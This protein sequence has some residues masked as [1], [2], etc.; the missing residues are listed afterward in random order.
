MD[1]VV[2]TGPTTIETTTRCAALGFV[3]G[4][5]SQMP[6][7]I[8]AREL[9]ERAADLPGPLARLAD[10]RV[11][12]VLALSAAGEVVGDKLP[13]APSRLK[14]EPLAG[15][16]AFGGAAGAT[17]ALAAGATAALGAGMGAAGAW[18]G[19]VAG[20]RARTTIVRTTGLPDPAV[21]VAEDLI[22]LGLGF[23]AARGVRRAADRTIGAAGA[24]EI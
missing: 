16:I 21:A 1:T 18:L 20:H 11:R 3:A 2:T 13:F 7:A 4:L 8:L 15:R 6:L 22:A 14:Q 17:A 23:W 24:Y 5:R 9:G 12:V 10:E 19:A